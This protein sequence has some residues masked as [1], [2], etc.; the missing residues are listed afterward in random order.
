MRHERGPGQVPSPGSG[1]S[2]RGAVPVTLP[3]SP[4]PILRLQSSAGNRA[5]TAYLQHLTERPARVPVQRDELSDPEGPVPLD[6]APPAP[7][8][9]K[10]SDS[11]TVAVTEVPI[12][13]RTNA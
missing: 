3:E 5:V 6:T 4:S 10:F 8:A 1:T 7:A 2:R 9:A 13:V 11:V 12:D